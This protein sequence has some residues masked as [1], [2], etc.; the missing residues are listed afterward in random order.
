MSSD[1]ERRGRL[2]FDDFRLEAVPNGNLILLYNRDVPGVI[3]DIGSCLGRH[4]V[5]I[6]GMHNGRGDPGGTAINMVNID[7]TVDESVLDDCPTS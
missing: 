4:R 7:G 1:A 2:R 3:G 6:S 5:N